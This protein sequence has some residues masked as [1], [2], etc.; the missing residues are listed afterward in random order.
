[1]TLKKLDFPKSCKQQRPNV[2][3]SLNNLLHWSLPIPPENFRQSLVFWCFQG[4]YKEVRGTK[5]VNVVSSVHT[6][7]FSRMTYWALSKKFFCKKNWVLE[8]SKFEMFLFKWKI[9]ISFGKNQSQKRNMGPEAYSQLF[10]DLM[11]PLI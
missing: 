7:H 8:H 6:F 9:Y 10:I 4:V 1:M 2:L 3:S 5:W 11:R